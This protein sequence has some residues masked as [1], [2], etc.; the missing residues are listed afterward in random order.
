[1]VTVAHNCLS[2]SQ[3]MNVCHR[4][5]HATCLGTGVVMWLRDQKGVTAF[6]EGQTVQVLL[7]MFAFSSWNSHPHPQHQ[8]F[9]YVHFSFTLPGITQLLTMSLVTVALFLTKWTS[10]RWYKENSDLF[11]M[12]CA[13]AAVF[14]LRRISWSSLYN[15]NAECSF[16]I[17]PC[18]GHHTLDCLEQ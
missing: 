8:D 16:S 1:M 13:P 3:Y 10:S 2:L 6:K 5:L 15:C 18:L 17:S 11:K 14:H 9:S 12:S 4:M 7:G